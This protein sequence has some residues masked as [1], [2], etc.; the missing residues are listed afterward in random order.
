MIELCALVVVPIGLRLL[1]GSSQKSLPVKNEE[2]E[3]FGLSGGGKK[4]E[5]APAQ[6]S[7]EG[8]W[9]F[10]GNVHNTAIANGQKVKL[11]LRGFDNNNN[12]FLMTSEFN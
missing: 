2:K 1:F 4:N 11:G 10:Q 7:H 12:P 8:L 9:A 3:M 5:V 6:N